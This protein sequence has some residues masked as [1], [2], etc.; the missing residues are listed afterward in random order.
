[1]KLPLAAVLGAGP[2]VLHLAIVWESWALLAGFAAIAAAAAALDGGAHRF[3][4]GALA[5]AALGIAGLALLDARA[6]VPLA[7]VWPAAAYLA[8]AWVFGRTLRRGRVPLVE[9]MA[10]MIDHGEHLPHELVRYTRVLTWVWT[11]L[12]LAMAVAS[13]L[14]ARFASTVAWSF[15]SNVL[16]YAVLAA[17]FF[18]EYPYRVRRFP[19]YAHTH[20]L[21]VAACL[22][23]R[24][25]ELFR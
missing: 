1:M 11:L 25:P 8:V 3:P 4:P 7:F 24:A 5:L 19:Q 9:R 17:L 10:R 18:A 20:P 21:A 16:S 2:L 6:V 23:R 14:L 22:A 15:F 13:V 12:P